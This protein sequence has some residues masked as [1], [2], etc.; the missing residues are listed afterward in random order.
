MQLPNTRGQQQR[1]AM[2]D[3]S[4]TI[5]TGGTSQ[6]VLPEAKSRS[7]FVFENNST[8]DNMYLEFGS[9]R[10]RATIT[11]GVVTS[12]AIT[13]A[14]FGF[15]IPPIVHFYGGGNDGWDMANPT[16]NTPG[17][18]G[19]PSPAHPAHGVA[20]LTGNS[21]SSITIN[22]GGKNYKNAPYVMMMNSFNDPFGCAAPA[23]GTG[24]LLQPGGSFSL[25]GTACT[26]DPIS[27]YCATTSSPF[28][29][30]YML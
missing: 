10:A 4:G 30:K 26:T 9:A 28:T 19:W 17:I 20:V 14:G 29:C 2:F 23:V 1:D 5:T 15:T 22:D 24:F 12:I 25:N 11:S 6:L 7:F 16:M 21:V 13:N 18:P 8:A 27:V 3:A